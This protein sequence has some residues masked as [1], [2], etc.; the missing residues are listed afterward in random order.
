MLI[1]CRNFEKVM[2]NIDIETIKD[3]LILQN[4]EHLDEQID[5]IREE[6]IISYLSSFIG[7][8]DKCFTAYSFENITHISHQ[9]IYK[10]LERK[11]RFRPLQRRRWCFCIWA[12]W[13]FI[14]DEMKRY[15]LKEKEKFCPET[16]KNNFFS[17]FEGE[18][19]LAEKLEKLGKLQQVI[20]KYQSYFSPKTKK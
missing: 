5:T 19:I 10:V 1:I 17:V 9:T 18:A 7:R 14:V 11:A 13:D 15:S 3:K 8:K 4:L 16:F 2:A 6:V 12:K 20:D